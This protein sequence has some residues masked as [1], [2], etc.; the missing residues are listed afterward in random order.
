MRRDTLTIKISD[1]ADVRMNR[2]YHPHSSAGA[3]GSAKV[4]FSV[5][6]SSHAPLTPA[7]RP[8]QDVSCFHGDKLYSHCLARKKKSVSLSGTVDR[9]RAKA[10][11]TGPF[12]LSALPLFPNLTMH[13]PYINPVCSIFQPL[14]HFCFSP[15]PHSRPCP[16]PGQRFRLSE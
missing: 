14:T 8:A 1:E 10:Q 5:G 3:H 13:L 16:I 11:P 4:S 7:K 2:S 6:G 9:G 12:P 15:H